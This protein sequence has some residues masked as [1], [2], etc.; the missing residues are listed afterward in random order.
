MWSCLS[1]VVVVIRVCFNVL[2]FLFQG[3]KTDKA[4]RFALIVRGWLQLCNVAP[5]GTL[6]QADL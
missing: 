5:S 6:C 3:K 4:S 1:T 2:L